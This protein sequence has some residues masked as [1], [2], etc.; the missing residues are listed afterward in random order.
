MS[1]SESKA[2]D[3]MLWVLINQHDADFFYNINPL[4]SFAI[5]KKT[6]SDCLKM[7]KREE[8][9]MKELGEKCKQ[10]TTRMKLAKALRPSPSPTALL[11]AF[12][13]HK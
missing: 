10:L 1:F 3:D 11:L 2:M 4:I 7:L 13:L 8:I 5:S 9:K 12:F 6:H